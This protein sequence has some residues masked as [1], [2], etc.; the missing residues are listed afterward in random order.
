MVEG[1]SIPWIKR[2]WNESAST[3]VEELQFTGGAADS[4]PND[5]AH[6]SWYSL[7]NAAT[8]REGSCTRMQSALDNCDGLNAVSVQCLTVIN[9]LAEFYFTSRLD[10]KVAGMS[11]YACDAS[12][13]R[14]RFEVRFE[15][16]ILLLDLFFI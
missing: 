5:C 14:R 16:E 11:H 1:S 8:A 9:I 4:E 3:D 15:G 10:S 2:R 13:N 6:E 7:E 12:L